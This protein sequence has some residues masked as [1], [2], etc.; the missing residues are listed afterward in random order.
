MKLSEKGY[1]QRSDP[2]FGPIRK[3]KWAEEPL[4]GD[5]EGYTVGAS[6]TFQTVS[7]R[8]WVNRPRVTRS[9]T[10]YAASETNDGGKSAAKSGNESMNIW[11]TNSR[12]VHR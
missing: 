8:G 1:E 2:V 12:V 10:Y 9:V 11:T 3:P 6:E 4:F 7:L 5:P